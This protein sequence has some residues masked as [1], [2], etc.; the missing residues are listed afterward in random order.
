MNGGPPYPPY[1]DPYYDYYHGDPYY[2]SY[3][4][5]PPPSKRNYS[6]TRE[7]HPSKGDKEKPVDK[8]KENLDDD[9]VSTFAQFVYKLF[10][11]Y[12]PNNYSQFRLQIVKICR[13][14]LMLSVECQKK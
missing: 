14:I 4:R 13:F 7:R 3:M 10:F 12:A 5:P 11:V 1:Y 9:F 2:G 8:H 6:D